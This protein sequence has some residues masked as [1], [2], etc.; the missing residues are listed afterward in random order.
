VSL[1]VGEVEDLGGDPM[2]GELGG[3]PKR[4]FGANVTLDRWRNPPQQQKLS[5]GCSPA[6]LRTKLPGRDLK[7]ME[8]VK[9]KIEQKHGK[10][11][12]V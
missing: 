2:L 11:R 9:Y 1:K 6:K 4:W 8:D 12:C 7:F 5:A 3:D 10:I